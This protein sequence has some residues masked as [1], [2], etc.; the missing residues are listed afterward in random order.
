[1]K[2]YLHPYL[3]TDGRTTKEMQ[4]INLA[5][6]RIKSSVETRLC[7]KDIAEVALSN[8]KLFTVSLTPHGSDQ[9]S[10]F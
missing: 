10:Y 3:A 7:F 4:L 2:F 8:Y 9:I 6:V 5:G 1:M